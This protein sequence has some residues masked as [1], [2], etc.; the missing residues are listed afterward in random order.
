MTSAMVIVSG[1]DIHHDL[2]GAA[3]V[4]QTLGTEAGLVTTAAMGMGRFVDPA[5]RTAGADVYL[6]YTSGGL[7]SAAQQE[8]LAAAV[9]GGKGLVAIHCSNVLGPSDQTMFPL[10]GNRY[11][12]HGPDHHEGTFEV[13]VAGD[14][15]ITR[16]VADFTLFDE[17]YEFEFADPSVDVLASRRRVSDGVEIPVLYA[18]TVGAGRV[19]YLALGHD[20]RAWGQPPFRTLVRQALTWASKG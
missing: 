17:Y 9:A 6:L 15:P 14:H 1:D 20:M 4:F 19:C 13:N 18:R 11:L 8:A 16:G 7:S 10:L 2:L 12:S 3:P 5:P